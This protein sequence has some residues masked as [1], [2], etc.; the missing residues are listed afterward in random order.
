MLGHGWIIVAA[1]MLIGPNV[2][3]R[4]P[5]QVPVAMKVVITVGGRTQTLRGTGRCAHEPHAWIY[6]APAALWRAEYR[7][8]REGPRLSLSFWRLAESPAEPQFT[9]SL[10]ENSAHHRIN[11]VSGGTPEGSG[12][13]SFRPTAT[14]GRFEISGKAQDG[15]GVEISIECAR[16]GALH[17]EG[18]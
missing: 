9:L 7:A 4:V 1:M 8:A 2:L 13:A 3:E 17:A 15:A 5:S 14:G 10:Q 12:R 11:T 18:G 6:G 16:F